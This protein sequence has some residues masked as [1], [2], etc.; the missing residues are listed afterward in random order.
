[1]MDALVVSNWDA[2]ISAWIKAR[3]SAH[4]CT[5]QRAASQSLTRKAGSALDGLMQTG[6][7]PTVN[8]AQRRRMTDPSS[9]ACKPKTGDRLRK[10]SAVGAVIRS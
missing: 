6:V 3:C 8:T 4:E 9:L 2:G 5:V 1:M 10:P 7:P